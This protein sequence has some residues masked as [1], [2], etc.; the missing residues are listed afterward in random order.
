MAL[1]R[2]LKPFIFDLLASK[3]KKAILKPLLGNQ[4]QSKYIINSFCY[5][6]ILNL[7]K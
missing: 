5:Q 2:Y 4:K 3:N 6:D 1:G 7:F